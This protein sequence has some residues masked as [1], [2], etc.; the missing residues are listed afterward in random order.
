MIKEISAVEARQKL[1]ELLA[2]VRYAG[3]KFVITRGG[4]RAAALVSVEDLER[5][6]RLEELLDVLSVGL[7][8]AQAQEP[9]PLDAL[10]K[11][12]ESLFGAK[13]ELAPTEHASPHP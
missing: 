2:R 9:L 10:L 11:Q 3:E 12:Y 8:K 1:G 5:L 6:E 13:P 4:K 7:L